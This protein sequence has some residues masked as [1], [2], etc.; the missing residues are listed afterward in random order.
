MIEDM[1]ARKLGAGT[2]RLHIS[3][4]QA[5]RRMVPYRAAIPTPVGQG[6]VEAT[7][8]VVRPLKQRVK[9]CNTS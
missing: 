3:R 5:V 1:T 8:F 6:V 2:Q 9:R 7:S 4:L